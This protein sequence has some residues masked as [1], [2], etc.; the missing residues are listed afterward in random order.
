MYLQTIV[1]LK[2]NCRERN[3]PSKDGSWEVT[4]KV[5]RGC[6]GLTCCYSTSRTGKV[7]FNSVVCYFNTSVAFQFLI[8]VDTFL[9]LVLSATGWILTWSPWRWVMKIFVSRPGLI[10]LLISW[11]WLPSPQSNI[12]QPT[13]VQQYQWAHLH[14]CCTQSNNRDYPQLTGIVQSLLDYHAL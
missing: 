13:S 4:L 14:R 5:E 6:C 9:F 1:T 2:N 11:I 10:E 12:Q 7:N 3:S 8:A